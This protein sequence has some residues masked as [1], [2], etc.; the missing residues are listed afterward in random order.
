VPQLENASRGEPSKVAAV[1]PDIPEMGRVEGDIVIE[2]VVAAT[3]APFVAAFCTELGKR[4][5]D[6][7]ASRVRLIRKKKNPSKA[8]LLVPTGAITTVIELDD[9][10]PEEAR[11]ALQDLD[12][13]SDAIRG[14]RL[15]WN[16][17]TEAWLPK[18]KA[19]RPAAVLVRQQP[20]RQSRSKR[21][22]KR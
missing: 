4:L 5:G 9:G 17:E 8:V 11:L 3:L 13:R 22:G 20:Q 19:E 16:V 7:V 18:D 2:A 21:S 15:C 6:T 14:Q 12:L 10:L 1:S